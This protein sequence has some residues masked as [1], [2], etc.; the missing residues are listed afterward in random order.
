LS[1]SL[2]STASKAPVEAPDGTIALPTEPLSNTT[3]TSTVGFPLESKILEVKV[4]E[5]TPVIVPVVPL[6][7][8]LPSVVVKLVYVADF[9]NEGVIVIAALL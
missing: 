7:V 9:F 8:L 6:T 3:S 1:P 5:I 2:N 4:L